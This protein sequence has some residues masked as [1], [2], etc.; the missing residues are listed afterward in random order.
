MA[1]KPKFAIDYSKLV[2]NQGQP[3]STT[4]IAIYKAALNKIAATGYRDRD[5]LLNRQDEVI[6]VIADEFPTPQKR[7][8]ALSAVFRVLGD[9]PNDK[10][11]KYYEFFQKCKDSV[12]E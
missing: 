2:S 10:R 11:V 6:K 8:V 12:D 3:L 1:P 4:S 5:D 9:I 7:R